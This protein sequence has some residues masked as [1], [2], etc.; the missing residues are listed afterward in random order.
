M[1]DKRIKY[2]PFR[3]DA[4]LLLEEF[5]NFSE[6]FVSSIY[7]GRGCYIENDKELQSWANELSVGKGKVSC[8][9]AEYLL[10]IKRNFH[11]RE[12]GSLRVNS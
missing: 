1:D 2:Y 3:D 7:G 11:I 5:E 12:G 10:V 4:K 9:T 8:I 6:E